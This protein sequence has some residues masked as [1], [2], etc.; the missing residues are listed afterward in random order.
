M[1]MDVLYATFARCAAR[2]RAARSGG[3]AGVLLC[4]TER[5][6]QRNAL[7]TLDADGRRDI[8]LAA[9]AIDREVAKPFWRP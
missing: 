1:L 7:A 8:G 2:N 9:G 5:A 4:W 3:L 6:R